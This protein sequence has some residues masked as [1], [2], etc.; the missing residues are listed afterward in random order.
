[1]VVEIDGSR[2]DAWSEHQLD[3]L[4]RELTAQAEWS[5]EAA[6]HLVYLA[7]NYGVFMLRNA[8]ALATAL[9]IEDGNFGF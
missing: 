5:S 1:M 2:A 8:C 6:S 3:L 4:R 7:T 9:K